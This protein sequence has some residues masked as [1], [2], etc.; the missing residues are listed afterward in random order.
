[1]QRLRYICAMIALF[2]GAGAVYG[3]AVNAT[4]LGTI[5]DSTGAT[6][7]NAKV[8][9]VEVNTGIVHNGLSNESGNYTF[10]DLPP[11]HYAV[12]RDMWGF[13]KETRRDIAVLVNSS[14]RADVQLQPGSVTEAIE[15]SGAPPLLETDRADTGLKV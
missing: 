5:T 6:V 9:A 8:S 14:T 12:T 7:A 11:G 13:K 4:L 15:V 3:Q 2:L 10:P 1:M